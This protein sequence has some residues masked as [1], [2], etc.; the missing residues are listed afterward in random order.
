MLQNIR[1]KSQ[2]IVVYSIVILIAITFSMWGVDALIGNIGSDAGLAEVNGEVIDR[3]QVERSSQIYIQEIMA[4]NPNLDVDTLNSDEIKQNV[5]SDLINRKLIEQA[6]DEFN[7]AVSDDKVESFIVKYPYF[8]D[9]SGRFNLENYRAA[10]RNMGQTPVNFRETVKRQLLSEQLLNGIEYSAFVLENEI[11]DLAYLLNQK[12]TFR[13][14][15]L[16]NNRLKDKINLTDEEIADFFRKNKSRYLS[17]EKI[18]V[19]YVF[20][21]P[22]SLEAEFEPSEEDYK[23][24]YEKYKISL[25]ASDT[26]RRVAQILIKFADDSEKRL[27]FDKLTKLKEEVNTGADFAKLA[28]ENSMDIATAAKGG[29]LGFTDLYAISPL[30]AAEANKLDKSGDLSE[31]VETKYGL[32]LIK[33]LEIE[34]PEFKS[35]AEVKS[36]LRKNFMD[37]PLRSKTTEVLEDLKNLSFSEEKLETLAKSAQLEIKKSGW[38]KKQ[39]L[40]GIW[41][42]DE[43]KRVLFSPEV[44]T[45]TAISAPIKLLNNK[46]LL[47]QKTAYDPERERKLAEVKSQVKADLTRITLA[48][49]NKKEAK[50]LMKSLKEGKSLELNWKMIS[51]S[52]RQ[53]KTVK[54]ELLR[55]V[56]S[57][58]PGKLPIFKLVDLYNGDLALVEL[59]KVDEQPKVLE[60]EVALLGQEL[61]RQVSNNAIN[62][63]L[64]SLRHSAKVIIN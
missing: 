27:A 52:D 45:D 8:A 3:H 2:G 20:F 25:L 19:N 62:N 59:L 23:S 47:F 40:N 17:D 49:L 36:E 22:K 21:D 18:N 4:N 34:T 15:D 33:L 63:F 13:Y 10:L 61:E 31:I 58:N 37:A 14:L 35:F 48:E 38:L 32:H 53:N 11:T 44:V 41:L 7:L 28:K 24:E 29:D 57:M 9:S 1:N 55:E 12:R 56:F 51:A 26:K 5:L 54:S 64:L 50:D 16:E 39:E 60:T 6:S 43:V 30:F 46:Y 42:Q